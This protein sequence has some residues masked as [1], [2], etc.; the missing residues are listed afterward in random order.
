M[1]QI[2]TVLAIIATLSMSSCGVQKYAHQQNEKNVRLQ[3]QLDS[4]GSIV[5][6]LGERVDS[7][8]QAFSPT[9]KNVPIKKSAHKRNRSE[10]DDE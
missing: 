3:N 7:L 10:D 2:V 9:P 5:W 1:K 8:K 6:S 4:L